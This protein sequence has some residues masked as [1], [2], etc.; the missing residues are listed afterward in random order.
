MATKFNSLFDNEIKPQE[1]IDFYMVDQEDATLLIS[2][3]VLGE[4]LGKTRS[5]QQLEDRQYG[6]NTN[7]ML[8]GRPCAARGCPPDKFCDSA[9]WPETNFT[10]PKDMCNL[11][12]SPNSGVVDPAMWAHNIDMDSKL[13]KIDIIDSK[14]HLKKHKEN[15]CEKNPESCPIACHKNSV[16]GDYLLPNNGKQWDINQPSKPRTLSDGINK[17]LKA[18]K[19]NCKYAVDRFEQGA[20]L[21][22]F[23]P[24][25]RRDVLNW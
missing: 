7:Y 15:P 21:R 4:D 9:G 2:K 16:A 17:A 25:K 14:C 6:N 5:I 10:K 20:A 8:S 1:Q 19:E 18:R 22:H 3:L 13:K 11:P 24:T 23:R 12:F